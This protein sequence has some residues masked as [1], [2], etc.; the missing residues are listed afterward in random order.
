TRPGARL[1]YAWDER[2]RLGK[3]R[4]LTVSTTV[5]GEVHELSGMFHGYERG[6][7]VLRFVMLDGNFARVQTNAGWSVRDVGGGH[8]PRDRHRVPGQPRDRAVEVPRL[9]DHRIGLDAR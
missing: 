5:D 4:L 2:L 7:S 1:H 3:G 9:R 6:W 8:P